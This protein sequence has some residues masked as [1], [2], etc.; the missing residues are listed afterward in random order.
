MHPG[1]QVPIELFC[2]DG[3]KRDV[4]NDPSFPIRHHTAHHISGRSTRRWTVSN[5]KCWPMALSSGV[6]GAPLSVCP[7][8]VALVASVM[9]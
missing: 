9:G 5:A 3:M 8:I 1:K 4:F 7:R 2:R 6:G